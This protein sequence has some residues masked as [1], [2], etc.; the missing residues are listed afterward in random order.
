MEHHHHEH[1]PGD[2]D[3]ALAELLDLDAEVLGSYL[4]GV[5]DWIHELAAGWSCRRIIDLGCGTGTGALALL[6]R[7]ADAEVVAVDVSAPMLAR[8]QAKARDLGLADRVRTVQA[9]L[10]AAWPAVDS[11][12]LDSADLDSADLVWA[13]NSLHHMADPDQVLGQVFG[14]IRPGGLLAVA[15]MD[16]LPR[17]LPDDLGP[18]LGRPG[19]EARCHDVL[20]A[21]RA[22]AVPLLGSDW[23]PRL[24]GARFVIETERTFAIDL[25]APL[26][27]SAGRYAQASL[28]RMRSGLDGQMSAGDLAALDTLIDSDGPDGVLRRDDLRIRTERTVWIARRP[29]LARSTREFQAGVAYRDATLASSGS[30]TPTIAQMAAT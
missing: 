23:G 14:L 29:A 7:F 10:D 4:S 26:A 25:K 6:R 1:H 8:V 2:D 22:E 11:A 15:E 5:I 28:R 19:L 24:A 12:D 9:D 3:V 16:G 20:A 17:F 27:A 30:M 21:Q 13:S 18:G